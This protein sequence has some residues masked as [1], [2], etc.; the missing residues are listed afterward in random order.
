MWLVRGA[1]CLEPCCGTQGE[2]EGTWSAL[3]NNGVAAVAMEASTVS[4]CSRAHALQGGG[5]G[6]L[7]GGWPRPQYHRVTAAA[8]VRLQLAM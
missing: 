6:P 5:E 2:G 1:R 7:A 3:L 4:A 8:V